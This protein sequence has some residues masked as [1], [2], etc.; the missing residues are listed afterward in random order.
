MGAAV[1]LE[2]MIVEVLNPQ[3][4]TGDAE[5]PNGAQLVVGERAWFA[6]KR[7]LLGVIPG[8]QPLHAVGK[9]LQ[10]VG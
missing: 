7:D 3:A 9:E 6:F 2:D 5:V 4:Q 10:L 8:Q 1:D